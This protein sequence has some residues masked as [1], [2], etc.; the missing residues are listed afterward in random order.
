MLN[1]VSED[2]VI[3]WKYFTRE[4]MDLNEEIITYLKNINF[5]LTYRKWPKKLEWIINKDMIY[6]VIGP[7]V[8]VVVSVVGAIILYKLNIPFWTWK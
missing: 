6:R 7:I 2:D 8:S 1:S 4:V 3:K 5:H